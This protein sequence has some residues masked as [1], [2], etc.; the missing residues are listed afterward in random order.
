V[1]D[2]LGG[3]S[4]Y[5]KALRNWYRYDASV[6]GAEEAI[7]AGETD[8]DRV[9]DRDPLLLEPFIQLARFEPGNRTSWSFVAAPKTSPPAIQTF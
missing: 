6:I 1:Q 4:A 5:Y 8:I 3:T 7:E 9:S 2:C